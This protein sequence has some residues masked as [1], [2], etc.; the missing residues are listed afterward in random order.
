[1]RQINLNV[2]ARLGHRGKLNQQRLIVLFLA[3]VI[4]PLEIARAQVSKSP[5]IDLASCAWR[6]STGARVTAL[7]NEIDL[8]VI[9]LPR[10]EPRTME[11]W[12]PLPKSGA[13][14]VQGLHHGA[15]TE[16][17]W[18][19][20]FE[21]TS[22]ERRQLYQ[23][24]QKRQ[25]SFPVPA[26]WQHDLRI[27]IVI[28]I[29]GDN[30]GYL[31][32]QDLRLQPASDELPGSPRPLS[33]TEGQAV[34][35]PAGDFLWA[36]PQRGPVVGYDLEWRREGEETQRTH[37]AAYF[38]SDAQGFWP[39]PWLW[40]GKY[41]WR[42]RALS[43]VGASGP[44]SGMMHFTVR[45][46]EAAKAPDM[47]PSSKR[48]ITILN[49]PTDDV[50]ADWA[51]VPEDVR[52]TF[53]FRTGGPRQYIAGILA[54][55]QAAG[56]P[57]ALQVNGPHNI[58]AGRWDRVPLALLEHWAREYPVLKAFYICEQQVQGGVENPDVTSYLERLIALGAELGRPVFWAD[59]NWGGNI[60]LEVEAHQDFARF[61]KAHYRYV[62]PLWKM[63]G[64]DAPY[65]APAGL[66]GLWLSHTVAAWGA[67]PESY[68]WTEAGFTTLGEQR[69]YKEGERQ[70]A[71]LVIFQ[72]L[73]LLGASAGAEIYSFEPAI[74]YW[75][76]SSSHQ[77]LEDIMWPL[78]RMLRGSVIPSLPEVQAA[79][80][81]KWVLAPA[82]LVFRSEYTLP[83]RQLFASTLGLAYPF[84]M[85]PES[86]SCYWI[87]IVPAAA[88]TTE[89]SPPADAES[90]PARNCP[91]P[92]PGEAAVFKAG[93][94]TFIFNS[95]VNWPEQESFKINLVGALAN[96]RLGTNG[97]VTILNE[98]DHQA[99]LWF[100]ARRGSHLVMDFDHPVSWRMLA[101]DRDSAISGRLPGTPLEPA[102][103]W[104]GPVHHIDVS[105]D[106]RPWE[107]FVRRE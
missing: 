100:F 44:W 74:D 13:M 89:S 83:V 42:V 10:A 45:A 28:G 6:A 53:L 72:E 99:H 102:S 57:I 21:R 87:P 84:Q 58:I 17:G 70:D 46:D 105:A 23:G 76:S 88:T 12:V 64:G 9:S 85:V 91:P 60:W 106:Q 40:P 71:P 93:K 56:A 24:S 50:K 59:A 63:N 29:P 31:H 4:G 77:D 30:P 79:T 47:L 51:V 80:V 32:L 5:A 1:M 68:Y 26:E 97:W 62:Y 43:P 36:C 104:S 90:G 39:A 48:P 82:D 7:G 16:R 2:E 69:A 61:L 25:F 8:E 81:R 52:P 20:S 101:G 98:N 96:G 95:R 94:A 55:A 75:K 41:D 67:Q 27:A 54:A 103:A 49:L 78:F 107:V 92:V 65:L 66:L 35:P 73:A 18:T 33:P 86:G 14:V 11:C 34:T 19:F 3:M 37:I 22:G 15:V 38:Q